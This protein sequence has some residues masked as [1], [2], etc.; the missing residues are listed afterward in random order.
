MSGWVMHQ[1]CV[2]VYHDENII[3]V[4]ILEDIQQTNTEW[5]PSVIVIFP[6]VVLFDYQKTILHIFAYKSNM[7]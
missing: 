2:Y 3:R 5:F 1:V 6:L 4:E 7:K